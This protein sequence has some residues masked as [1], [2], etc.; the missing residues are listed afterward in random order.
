LL[1][2]LARNELAWLGQ[3]HFENLDGLALQLQPDP[4]LADFS[5]L[6]IQFERAEMNDLTVTHRH[7]APQEEG[8]IA[9]ASQQ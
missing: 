1:D 5:A 8:S 6:R 9:E 2:L 7:G 4:G 3:Q